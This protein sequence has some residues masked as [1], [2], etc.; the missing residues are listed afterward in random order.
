MLLQTPLFVIACILAFRGGAIDRSLVSPLYLGAGLLFGHVTFGASVY[1]THNVWRDVMEH[2]LDWRGLGH[3]VIETPEM[4]LRFVG[5]SITEELIY[6]VAAQS[7]LIAAC[8]R[9]WLAIVVVAAAFSVVHRHFFRNSIEQS[10]EFAVF[11]VLLGALYYWTGSLILVIV[12]HTVRNLESLYLEYLLRVD[13]LGDEAKAL[14]A[15]EEQ[16]MRL[17]VERS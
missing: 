17:P 5:V 16:Y 2:F 14:Q 9:A 3:F 8:G 4:M 7:L 6:R 1:A 11:S 15:I 13:E 10:A 12:V